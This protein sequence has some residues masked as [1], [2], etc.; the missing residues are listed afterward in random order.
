MEHQWRLDYSVAIAVLL[1]IATTIE[2]YSRTIN[3]GQEDCTAP[4]CT[5][6]QTETGNYLEYH[7]LL[8]EVQCAIAMGMNCTYRTDEGIFYCS[9]PIQGIYGEI[10]FICV[11]PREGTP[12]CTEGKN[13]GELCTAFDRVIAQLKTEAEFR[14]WE[15]ISRMNPA[16]DCT[17]TWNPTRAR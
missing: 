16:P 9:C 1:L 15:C 14:M 8:E 12:E 11:Y 6:R 5:P 4:C 7:C 2:S 13:A 3:S 10:E 17:I